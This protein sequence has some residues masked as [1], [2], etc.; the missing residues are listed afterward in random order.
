MAALSLVLAALAGQVI[1]VSGHW[2]AIDRQASCEALTRSPYP[3]TRSRG[4]ATA[5][6]R[7]T[8]DRRQW[9]QFHVTLSRVP[10]AGTSV[11]LEIGRQPFLLVARG[12]DGWSRSSA[13][14]QAIIAAL[15]SASAMKVT[16]RSDSGGRFTDRFEVRGAAT[17]IDMAAARCALRGAGKIR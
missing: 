1:G 2:A 3:A 15:R 9:G 11:M 10:R 17:A 13:Q 6:F 8:P 5:G 4:A 12:T 16:A 14:D 7:F